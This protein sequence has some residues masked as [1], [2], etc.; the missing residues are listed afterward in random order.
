[1]S[2]FSVLYPIA[3]TISAVAFLATKQRQLNLALPQANC[4]V[5]SIEETSTAQKLVQ[6]R[7]K[8]PH[9][10]RVDENFLVQQAL[11]MTRNHV[12]HDTLKGPGLIEIYEVYRKLGESEIVCL[13]KLGE[14]L[15]GYPNIVHGGI[16]HLFVLVII[17]NI[18]YYMPGITALL[19]D[20]T[21]GWVFLALDAPPAVT[22][23]LTVNYK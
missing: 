23:N 1:M 4:G 9:F 10:I 18:I 21:F 11:F 8:S 5:P 22:A 17:L 15:N 13:I 12:L 7:P 2:R 6:L 20:N 14:R 19:F 3:I 16:A